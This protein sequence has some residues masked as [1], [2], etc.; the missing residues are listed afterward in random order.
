MDEAWLVLNCFFVSCAMLRHSKMDP[1]E[2]GRCL[3]ITKQI[4]E[5][6]RKLVARVSPG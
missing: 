1:N 3:N 5:R 6:L 4:L 2:K